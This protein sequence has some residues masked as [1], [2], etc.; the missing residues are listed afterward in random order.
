MLDNQ[1]LELG[2]P[3]SLVLKAADCIVTYG[4]TERQAMDCFSV[5]PG[6]SM[7]RLAGFG[8][9]FT[10][11]VNHSPVGRCGPPVGRDQCATYSGCGPAATS[12]IVPDHATPEN[13]ADSC[14]IKCRCAYDLSIRSCTSVCCL[15]LRGSARKRFI[16]S[17]A[18]QWLSAMATGKAVSRTRAGLVGSG[19]DFSTG[20]LHFVL[21]G[22][23]PFLVRYQ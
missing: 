10:M 22:D 4:W 8:L 9:L 7:D 21:P 11:D 1:G 17:F 23:V 13:L 12:H 3:P 20:P 2:I 18:R 6:R 19:Y 5:N 14:T 15:L 16:Y